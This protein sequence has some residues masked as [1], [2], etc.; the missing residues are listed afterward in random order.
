MVAT[1][2]TYIYIFPRSAYYEYD[3]CVC[4]CGSS[5]F[6]AYYQY[7]GPYQLLAQPDILPLLLSDSFRMCDAVV[8]VGI[9]AVFI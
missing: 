2:Q 1:M 9:N 8:E 3:M 5:L 7:L 4:V 6:T